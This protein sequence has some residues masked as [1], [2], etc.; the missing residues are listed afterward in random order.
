[1]RLV[2]S[3]K[4]QLLFIKVKFLEDVSIIV[5]GLAKVIGDAA[6][7]SSDHVALCL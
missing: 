3:P 7:K 5:F 6:E 2:G 4:H 1:M